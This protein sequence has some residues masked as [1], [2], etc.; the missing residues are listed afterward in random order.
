MPGA[1]ASRPILSA[2]A[3]YQAEDWASADGSAQLDFRASAELKRGIDLELGAEALVALDASLSKFLS[4][5]LQG[6]A[7]AAASVRAQIQVPLDLFDEAGLA[8]RLQAVAEAAASIQLGIGLDVGDFLALAET[9]PR[10]RG[11]ALRLLKVFLDEVQIQGGVMAKAAA[12][13]MAYANVAATGRLIETRSGKAG[14]TIVAEAG[15]GLKAGA[16]YR[17]FAGFNLTDPRRL[18]RRTVDVVVDDTLQSIA[19]RTQDTA[20]Q[21]MIEELRAPAKMALR[22]CFELGAEL[23][24]G[25]GTFSA[26]R[27]PVIAQRCVQVFFE[28]AQRYLLEKLAEMGMDIFTE[29]LRAMGFAENAW[30]AAHP[31][32][33][34]LAARLRAMPEDPF[35]SNDANKLYWSSAIQDAFAL[36]TAL[37]GRNLHT[38]PWV[39]PLAQMWAASQLMFVTVS[40]ITSSGARATLLDNAADAPFPPFTG[41][42]SQPAPPLIRAHISEA[43]RPGGTPR[44]PTLEDLV[45]YLLRTSVLDPLAQRHPAVRALVEMVAGSGAAHGPVIATIMKNLG[46]F[47][48][49]PGNRVD[50]QR[51]LEVVLAGLRNYVNERVRLDVEPAL[52]DALANEAP[53]VRLYLDEVLL[54]TLRFASDV[55]FDRASRWASGDA[56]G[57]KALREACSALVM[58]VLGRTLVVS[59]DVLMNKA[60]E[61][62]SGAFRAAVPALNQSQGIIDKLDALVPVLDRNAIKDGVTEIFE[63]AADVFQPLS[64][65]QRARIRDL[66]YEIMDTAPARPDAAFVETLRNESLVPNAEA[67]TALAFELGEMIGENFARLIQRILEML[68][69]AILDLIEDLIAEVERQITAWIGALQGLLEDLGQALEHLLAEIAQLREDVARAADRLLDEADAFLGILAFGHRGR[70]K[71]AVQATVRE[72]CL[73][74]LG[75]IPGYSDLPRSTRRDVRRKLDDV[76]D[77]I[78]DEE[79]FDGL[80]D[81]LSGI[82]GEAQDFLQD[83]R[84]IDPNDDVT[85]ALIDL[86]VDRIEDALRDTFG[87]RVTI[88]IEIK[89]RGLID[90]ELDLGQVRVDTSDLIRAI[91][92]FARNLQAITSA[93]HDLGEALTDYLVREQL[94]DAREVEEEDVRARR[95]DAN[96]RV[97]ECRSA[98][99]VRVVQPGASAA[100]GG[101]IPVEIA[102]MDVPR[103]FLGL[104]EDEVARVVVFL[105]EVPLDLGRFDVTEG[106]YTSPPTLSGF[107]G[108]SVRPGMPTGAFV[109]TALQRLTAASPRPNPVFQARSKP[110]AGR[111]AKSW[112]R[113]ET[114]SEKRVR[115]LESAK[116]TR[117]RAVQIG[118]KLLTE[119]V[120]GTTPGRRPRLSIN[121]RLVGES[122]ASLILRGKLLVGELPEGF[123]TLTAVLS[124]GRKGARVSE[125]VVF[126]WSPAGKVKRPPGSLRPPVGKLPV[127]PAVPAEQLAPA[128]REIAGRGGGRLARIGPVVGTTPA[129]RLNFARAP[130]MSRAVEE[131][132]SAIAA[133]FERRIGRVETARRQVAARPLRRA[134]DAAPPQ[135]KPPDE[136]SLA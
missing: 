73:G 118:G 19:A 129:G 66:L 32:R 65:T 13:A 52:R 11:V 35:E 48:A 49:Q 82:A 40:R 84:G 27:A 111:R 120:P 31:Q 69:T 107:P 37:G 71:D 51:S 39:A 78:L 18:I 67:A 99:S 2:N 87:S 60:L 64:S 101:D 112:H 114:G 50:P 53:E 12:A 136:G 38:E 7:N 115:P 68:A 3:N 85:G 92:S 74:V 58:K 88:R 108:Y 128:L 28:E 116:A 9:D 90:L 46:A 97:A 47:V 131:R 10:M 100:Y 24:S 91:R 63:L 93:A 36:A 119:S 106:D 57:H 77:S 6:Q 135:V 22:I 113:P 109:G 130:V 122:G 14:F 59:V 127:R 117:G 94:L 42:V 45:A 132:R 41:A 103:S 43:L 89:L 121:D 96:R 80:A 110:A 17:M 20:V 95:E 26:S 133:A 15:L 4:I 126:H 54:A 30:N 75:D 81:A 16:G 44:D 102:F 56:A 134:L 79:L 83:V 124:T 8:I 5:D 21:T 123:H 1:N 105:D 29:S 62:V 104:D 98:G 25:S 61:S 76:L 72:A 23:A 125:S 33:S 55:V 70:L 34:A 86:L